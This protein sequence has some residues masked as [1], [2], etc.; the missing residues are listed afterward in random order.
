MVL[1]SLKKGIFNKTNLLIIGNRKVSEKCVEKTSLCSFKSCLKDVDLD[2]LQIIDKSYGKC[3]TNCPVDKCSPD[4]ICKDV[5][6][7]LKDKN[8]KEVIISFEKIAELNGTI[9]SPGFIRCEV[10]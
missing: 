7:K 1:K 10:R 5:I 8:K 4:I 3:I 9:Y 6:W 2:S